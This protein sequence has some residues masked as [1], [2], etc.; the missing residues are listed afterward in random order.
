MAF[1][2]QKT[3]AEIL[4][5][6]RNLLM[7]PNGRVWNNPTLN[8][9]IDDW[10]N[11]IQNELPLVTSTATLVTSSATNSYT[12]FASDI[13]QPISF[14]WNGVQ[15][16]PREPEDMYQISA[17]F[18]TEE[19]GTPRVVMPINFQQFELHPEPNTTGT[20]VIEYTKKLALA[21]STSTTELPTWIVY[22]CPYFVAMSAYSKD[23]PLSDQNKAN[24]YK[25]IFKQ[26]LAKVK[27]LWAKRESNH[28]RTFRPNGHF[29]SN[30][31]LG[32][33]S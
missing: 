25:G 10:Q 4:S 27:E 31:L 17:T 29:Q 24:V 7:D 21:T 1:S 2:T 12:A 6:C 23:S 11:L 9:Y 15:L 20:A 26:R 32:K 14:F 28:I 16:P 3:Q 13:D 8:G 22:T 19:S 33:R 5:M 30:I 18:R